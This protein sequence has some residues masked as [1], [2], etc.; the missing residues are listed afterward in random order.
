MNRP[1]ET[2]AVN[3][4]LVNKVRAMFATRNAALPTS[5]FILRGAVAN[6]RAQIRTCEAAVASRPYALAA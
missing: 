5:A 4:R 1:T 6:L 3:A 2:F